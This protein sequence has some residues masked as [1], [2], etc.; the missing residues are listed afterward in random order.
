MRI[1]CGTLLQ[2]EPTLVEENG[3]LNHHKHGTFKGGPHQEYAMRL[4]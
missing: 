1:F 3:A 2:T 4:P